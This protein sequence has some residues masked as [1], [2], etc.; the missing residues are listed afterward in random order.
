MELLG[1][2]VDPDRGGLLGWLG[3]LVDEAVGV[4]AERVV[5]GFL[6]GGV[7]LGGLT[8]VDLVGCHQADAE[9]A[10]VLVVPVEEGAA[11]GLG[12]LDAYSDE[13]APRFRD[14]CAP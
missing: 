10:V 2:R 7:D 14:D 6:A 11:E 13:A 5:E 3:G 4:G 12:V 9:M 1:R 8:V